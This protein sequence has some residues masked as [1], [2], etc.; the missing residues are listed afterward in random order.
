MFMDMKIRAPLKALPPK[1]FLDALKALPFVTRVAWSEATGKIDGRL[2]LQAGEERFTLDVV[3]KRSYL[4]RASLHA[5]I[6]LASAGTHRVILFAR[7]VPRP[8][9][10]QLVAAGV[11]FLDQSGNVHLALGKRY[12]RTVLGQRETRRAQ[13]DRAITA[14]HVQLLFLGAADPSALKRPVREIAKLA[15]ISKSK[16]AEI[17]QTLTA[18][19]GGIGLD[20]QAG[21]RRVQ[22]QLLSGYT[23]VLRP[24]LMLGRFRAQE[25]TPDAFL[26][27]LAA[28]APTI[29]VRFALTGGPAADRLQHFYRGL[30]T[31]LFIDHW[32]QALQQQL[33]LLPDRQ[34]PLIF[35]RAFGEL[36]YWK[37]ING[38]T[39]AHP[40]LI[41]AELMHSDDPRAHEAAEELRRE[42][43][44][45]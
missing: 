28:S 38:M 34:G 26:D 7:Y 12:A 44:S 19:R 37:T 22:E 24:K 29:G 45:A 39:L 41:Y 18:S 11:N 17:R 14:A 9:G 20:T 4:D 33:R 31:P 5:L 30:E 15:G 27:R 21:M 1:V 2:T 3:Q 35:L 10:E 6:A 16:A 43:L 42:Y 40:W 32:T 25:A 13:K 8:A 23:G 36:V